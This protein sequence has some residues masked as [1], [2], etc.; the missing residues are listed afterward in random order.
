MTAFVVTDPNIG[1]DQGTKMPERKRHSER[2]ARASGLPYTIVRPSWIGFNATDQLEVV[3]EKG[4]CRT[5]G[6]ASDGVIGRQQITQA[7]VGALFT[8]EARSRALDTSATQ[9]PQ[10]EW[11]SRASL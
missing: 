3:L 11:W 7:L 5:S 8:D 4:E 9:G 10:I 2:L 1:Y 6:D